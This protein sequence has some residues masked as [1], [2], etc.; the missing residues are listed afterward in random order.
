M[1]HVTPLETALLCLA[2]F[3]AATIDAI[4]GG[5]GLITVPAL[6]AVGLPPHMALGTN[7]GQSVWGS[8]AAVVRYARAGLLDRRAALLSFP[9]A[10]AGS[11]A[12]ALLVLRLSPGFLRPLILVLLVVAA[13][14]VALARVPTEERERP[15]RAKPLLLGAMAIGIGAYDG[16]FGPGT[17]T[18]LITGYVLL[19]GLSFRRASA[20]AKVVNFAA[21]LAA[22]IVFAIQGVVVWSLAAPMLVAQMAGGW[23]G[24]HLA[25]K[26]GSRFI[27][28]VV[29]VVALALVIK[30][31]R[32]LFVL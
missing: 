5:G 18:F 10:L 22:L 23:T 30:V 4:A 7:K 21:N 31:A 6:L 17:G 20:N 8:G 27:R 12:G 29:L 28:V 2:S 32:D 1:I 16:F 9:L 19:L 3:V 13:L 25:V 24:A 15:G 26:G 11:A 14:I